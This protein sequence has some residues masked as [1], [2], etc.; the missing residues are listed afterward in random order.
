MSKKYIVVE[1][2]LNLVS[3]GYNSHDLVKCDTLEIA[4]LQLLITKD[5]ISSIGYTNIE[6]ISGCRFTATS[7]LYCAEVLFEIRTTY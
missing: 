2:K 4:L 7:P 5:Y 6:Y 3:G 1:K